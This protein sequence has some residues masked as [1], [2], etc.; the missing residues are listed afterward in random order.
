MFCANTQRASYCNQ[1]YLV[2]EFRGVAIAHAR[3]VDQA[4]VDAFVEVE[5]WP[6]TMR[7]AD[8]VLH[9]ACVTLIRTTDLVL[10][11]ES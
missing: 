8:Y 5:F 7:F 6:E 9:T 4:F 2:P 3:A 10:K 1:H 11:P